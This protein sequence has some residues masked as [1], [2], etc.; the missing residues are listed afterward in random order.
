MASLDEVERRSRSC[1]PEPLET[2]VRP[3]LPTRDT[4]GTAGKRPHFEATNTDKYMH[5]RR[6]DGPPVA[7]RSRPAAARSRLCH[8]SAVKALVACLVVLGLV[9]CADAVAER[10]PSAPAGEASRALAGAPAP[11]AGLHA[12][13]GRL[14]G[15]GPGA[16]K[17]RLSDLEGHPVVVNKWA[18]WCGPCRAEF[19]HFGAV[20][21]ARGRDVAF[22]GVNALDSDSAAQQFLRLHPVPYPHYKDPDQ[23]IAKLFRGNA[24][25]PT[26]AFYDRRGRFV[27]ALQRYYSSERELVAD[28]DRYAR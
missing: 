15:G 14:L 23:E 21:L 20:A 19:T 12:Q 16:F 8:A 11:L 22:L 7:E 18:S 1:V 4:P 27:I 2:A 6:R 28:I 13:S 24:A 10:R 26:T 5:A 25:F 9:G 3:T 17:R